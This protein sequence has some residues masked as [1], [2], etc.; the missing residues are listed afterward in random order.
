M[1][2]IIAGSRKMRSHPSIILGY[3]TEAGINIEDITEIVSGKA[4]GIDTE[5]EIFAQRYNIPVKEFPADWDQYGKAAGPIRNKQMAV[6]ADRLFLI[7]DGKSPGSK[8]MK[9][10][11]TRLGKP[12]NE[13]II[14]EMG[15]VLP[16]PRA[17][18]WQVGTQDGAQ[19]GII[20]RQTRE[21][22]GGPPT[23]T[24]INNEEWF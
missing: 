18:H 4:K 24:V 21:W 10:T 12:V 15:T 16:R 17:P 1:K 14:L 22:Q 19:E 3:L 6:Y 13:K 2:L 20:V 9:S 5:G 11:M 8:N 7:W 23:V